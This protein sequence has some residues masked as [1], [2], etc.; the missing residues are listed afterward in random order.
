M[1]E[2]DIGIKNVSLTQP[3][4]LGLLYLTPNQEVAGSNPDMG[5]TFMVSE[6]A[7]STAQTLGRKG[8]CDKCPSSGRDVKQGSCAQEITSSCACKRSH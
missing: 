4:K 3:I 1:D 7:W 8:G 6:S 5:L 2:L